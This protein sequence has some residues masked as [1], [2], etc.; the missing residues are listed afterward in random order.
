VNYII[1]NDLSVR[2]VENIVKK[3]KMESESERVRKPMPELV[4]TK[5]DELSKKIR[6]KCRISYNE[7]NE[8]GTI[9]IRFDSLDQLDDFINK[10]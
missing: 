7:A 1:D 2:D 5:I 9:S 4:K 8:S 3:R 10:F 6:L